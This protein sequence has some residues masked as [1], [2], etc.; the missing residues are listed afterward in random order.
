MTVAHARIDR[1]GRI[2]I[3]GALRRALGLTPG[4]AAVL[5][6]DGPELR[7]VSRAEQIRRAQQLV[8]RYVPAERSLSQ[9]LIA[10]RRREADR[11]R[12]PS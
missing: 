11:P 5:T 6:P 1:R 12:S 10:Q 9:E 7:V 8:R 3:P 2:T 4:A